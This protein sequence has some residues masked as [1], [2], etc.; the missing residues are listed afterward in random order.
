MDYGIQLYSIRDLT[1]KN[2]EDALRQ[3]S[4]IGYRNVEFAGFFGHSAEEV[5]AMLRRYGLDHIRYAHRLGCNSAEPRRNCG[6]PQGNRHKPYHYPRH[7]P[8][9]PQNYGCLCCQCERSTAEAGSDGNDARFSSTIIRSLKPWRT[10]LCRMMRLF[11]CTALKLEIDTYWAY[12]A[13]RD[14]VALME[15]YKDRLQ[16][17]HIKDGD[18]RGHGTPLVWARRLVAAVYRQS[19]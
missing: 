15:Q 10:A 17:I 5:A 7:R 6:I 19:N 14:P 16:F 13:G 4:E 9:E 18:A 1:E 12:V 3:A 2:L 8:L 11:P